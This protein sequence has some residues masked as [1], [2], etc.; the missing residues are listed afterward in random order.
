MD[1][2]G[3]SPQELLVA[4]REARWAALRC[5]AGAAELNLKRT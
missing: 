2:A 3:V 5:G 1:W 4:L